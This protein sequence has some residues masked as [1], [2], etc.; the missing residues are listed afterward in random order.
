MANRLRRGRGVSF[1]LLV[2][3][4]VA[5]TAAP[6]LAQDRVALAEVNR[7][8]GADLR[9]VYDGRNVVLQGVVNAPP[10]R[11]PEYT[12]LGMQDDSAGVILA[13]PA[14]SNQ[15]DGYHPG[16]ELRVTAMVTMRLG[17][18]VVVPQKI[19]ELGRKPAPAPKTVQPHD[20]QSYRYI[21]RLVRTEARIASIAET[22]SGPSIT[23]HGAD[24][25][26]VF[27][28]QE[29]RVDFNPFA[30]FETG[31]LVEA[32]GVA[33]QY[34]PRPPYDHGF[35]L[36]LPDASGVI[37]K[38][39]A[40]GAPMLLLGG[41]LLFA[42]AIGCFMWVRE[43]RL[44][45]QRL[46]LRKTYQVSEEILGASS[47]E[48]IW[49]RIAETLPEILGVSRVHL[50]V[51]NRAA[52]TLDQVAERGSE[53]I[54]IPLAAPPAGT[55][56]GAAA[57][58]HYGV[59]LPIPDPSR[60]PFPIAT[61]ERKSPQS[62]LF[63]P[64]MAQGEMVGVMELDQDDRM[65]EFSADEQALAQ[66]MGNQIGA[67]LRLLAQRTVQAQLF[68]TEKMAAV[69]RLISGV[70]NE[71]QAP[72]QS[73]S[74]LAA[75]AV[76][77]ES[78]EGA[79]RDLKAIANESQKAS[80]IVARLV[81]YA[82]AESDARPVS[83]S[84]LLR[85][86]IEFRESEWKASGIKLTETISREPLNISGSQGQLEQV[87]LNLLVHA[88]QALAE[89]PR[90][91]LSIR[92]SLLAK[93][94]LVEISFSAPPESSK[95]EEAA[96]VLGV[97]RSVVAGHGGEVRLIE[98]P[99]VDPRFEVDLPMITR[100]R[101][102]AAAPAASAAGAQTDIGRG[103]TALVIEPEE[104]AQRQLIAL[105]S[106]RGFRVVPL[107]SADAGLDI[108]Q[109][110]RFDAAFCSVHAHGLNWVEVSER[111]H[112]R[113]GGFVLLSEGYDSELAK[114]FEGEGRFVLPKPVQ[115]S[116]LDRVLR[117]IDMAGAP[118]GKVINIRDIVA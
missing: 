68:R 33:S 104:S 5:F 12:A 28:P 109:R 41:C 73:I 118:S 42:L 101:A 7:R 103:M 71:L 38:Q 106:A 13:V 86:L 6:V 30:S 64:M 90:K 97:T 24:G 50:F 83:I 32:T 84:A 18:P 19:E 80:G 74:E 69:G 79:E 34:S 2:P 114:D 3:C 78:M 87:F 77:R 16:A 99:N 1:F 117:G 60:T 49:T 22:M 15:L 65:R 113:V 88:E 57:C 105:L 53:P 98:K 107:A 55:E 23:L 81:S 48:A 26:W 70:V 27:L 63:A 112:S 46:R 56:S 35:E 43:R 39:R 47:P 36:L 96:S 91:M 108:S 94:L 4:V 45:G 37:R 92:T 44:R 116:D 89:A 8:Q 9:P 29:R 40:L 93:R 11:F 31:D 72:L 100:E 52:K 76:E 95:P 51:Y 58:F 115:E 20:L 66:H 85:S 67:A 10:I 102:G 21:G 25:L 14:S 17:M 54:S 75:L 61:P 59:L 111:M 62:L 82:A 110:M